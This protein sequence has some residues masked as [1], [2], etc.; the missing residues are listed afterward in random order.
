MNLVVLLM[1][2]VVR[3]KLKSIEFMIFLE[4]DPPYDGVRSQIF[5]LNPVLPP[6]EAY[7]M[8]LG[9]D[10][11]Q[12]AMLGGGAMD[13]KVDPARNDQ[14]PIRIRTVVCCLTSPHLPMVLILLNVLV[15]VLRSCFK[16]HDYL[17][18]FANYKA[19]MYGPKAACTMT[20]DGPVFKPYLQICVFLRLCQ[21]NGVFEHKNHQLLEVARSLM[22][23]MYVPHHLWNHGVLTAT[24][25][26]NRTP[27]WVLDFKTLL[28]VLC[29]H[30]SPVSVS[31]LPLKVFG[32]VAYVHVKI[33][34]MWLLASKLPVAKM[35][36]TG[37]L[38]LTP[39]MM[40]SAS[41]QLVAKMV[42]TGHLALKRSVALSSV[43]GCLG[44][45]MLFLVILAKTSL[46]QD[47]F[48][49]C[50]CSSQIVIMSQVRFVANGY[51]QTYGVDYLEIFALVAKL[52]T[53]CVL[54]SI[55]ANCD[56]LLLQF[57]VKNMF[58]RG[59]LKED[60]YMDLPPGIPVTSK[61]GIVCKLLKFWYRLKQSPRAWFGR[62]AT[63]MKKFGYVQSNLD[64]TLFLKHHKGKLMALIIYVDDIIVIGD[65]KAEMQSLH[66]YLASKFEMKSLE[67]KMLD[68]KPIDTSSEQNHKLGMYPDQVPTH[69]ERYQRLVVKFIYLAHTRPDIAYAM[70]VVSQFMHSHSKD[71]MG[72]V[73]RILRYRKVTPGK[74]LM[75]CKYGHT[76]VGRYTNADWA[77]LVTNRR[78][79]SGYFT[80]IGGNLVTWRSKK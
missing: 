19:R 62:F 72:A 25:L 53:V 2:F 35:V 77:G 64:H 27:S 1:W 63:S 15:S 75:F 31:K 58:L 45:L 3:K 71:H 41:N 7:A 73:V 44:Q 55:D 39:K 9:E 33:V 18:W 80:Y 46:I 52:N 54:L 47:L 76:N 11:R 8:V 28:D 50:H 4:N 21:Q 70:S 68:C 24:Y 37:R 5:A 67:T 48:L 23:D 69:K 22:L 65:N 51:T 61:K 42:T 20:Q 10:T 60:I 30:T 40:L 16:E 74:G 66:K 49:P 34:Q 56:W 38:A 79:T 59:D 43:T 13:Q 78:S 12:S 6:L 26:I 17:D 57:D 32:C 14:S 29:A 36:T